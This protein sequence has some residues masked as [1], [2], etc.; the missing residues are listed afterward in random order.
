MGHDKLVDT[1]CWVCSKPTKQQSYRLR[2][3][4]KAVCSSQ[5]QKVLVTG[6]MSKVWKGGKRISNLGYVLVR[7]Y[8]KDRGEGHKRPEIFEHRL[9]MENHLGRR[10]KRSEIVHHKNKNTQDNRI[11]NLQIVSA[12]EHSKIH[13]DTF[14][15]SPSM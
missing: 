9:V 6:S 13:R 15:N 10:L 3:G 14:K 8:R 7:D 1:Q 5:C 4:R 11:E 2:K 12:S